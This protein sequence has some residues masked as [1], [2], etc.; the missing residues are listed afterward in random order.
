MSKM[1]D[2]FVARTKNQ[3]EQKNNGALPVGSPMYYYCQWCGHSSDVLPEGYYAAPPKKVCGECQKLID[4]NL[5]EKAMD[6][7]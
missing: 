7:V 4:L 1:I 3:P 2:K 5:M 6:S